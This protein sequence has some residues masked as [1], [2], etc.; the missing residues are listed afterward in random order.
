MLGP[1]DYFLWITSFTLEAFVVVSS[2]LRRDFTRYIFL[3]LYMFFVAFNTVG[4][5]ICYYKF[6]LA[7]LQY[8][9]YYY[10]SDSL[11]YILM[12]FVIIQFYQQVF[13]EMKVSR[14]IR[15]GAALLLG[16]TA[17][18]SFLVV[19]QNR[20]HLTTRFV[21]E[22]EQNLN[23]I[24]VVLTYLLWGAI[25]KLRE[26]RARL[27]QLVL[28]LGVYYSATAGSYA[29]RNLFRSPGLEAHVLHWLP[30]LF[31][32]WLPFAWAY[33]F[34]KVPEGARLATAR[35]AVRVGVR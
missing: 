27:V 34:T 3:N 9:Y 28:A 35:L 17:L 30:P 5:Y 23:F 32:T 8:F 21:V 18:F 14:Y 10:Y 7:S 24:G 6:G 1:F 31:G 4:L 22:L 20:D 16:L 12:Y 2:L 11:Q 13:I 25:V 33:T 29:L 26:A 15:G 19:H